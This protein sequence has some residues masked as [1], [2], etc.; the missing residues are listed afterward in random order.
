[1]RYILEGMPGAG[2]STLMNS[3][4]ATSKYPMSM[5]LDQPEVDNTI[6]EAGDIRAIAKAFFNEEIRRQNY[7]SNTDSVIFDRNY[8]STLAY[9][10]AMSSIDSEYKLAFSDIENHI[11]SLLTSNSISNKDSKMF[12]LIV[13]PAE[14]VKRRNEFNEAKYYPWFD[15]K[16]LH[17]MFSFYKEEIFKKYYTGEYIIMDTT[18]LSEASVFDIITKEII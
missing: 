17:S 4:K 15:D 6:M 18:N 10:Y 8:I 1:M 12:V 5:Y 9:N 2:K 3:L 13:E 16:F 11:S 14:S 7:I